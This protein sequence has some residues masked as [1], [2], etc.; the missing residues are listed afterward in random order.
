MF[1]IETAYVK[2]EIEQTVSTS[3][4]ERA[5]FR[6]FSVSGVRG[7]K[8]LTLAFRSVG[9]KI[10]SLRLYISCISRQ[11]PTDPIVTKFGLETFLGHNQLCQIVHACME[12]VIS[13]VAVAVTRV[14]DTWA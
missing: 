8:K 6:C 12:L 13:S 1:T 9:E 11:A 2:G 7:L 4:C 10:K 3:S 14:H 5:K